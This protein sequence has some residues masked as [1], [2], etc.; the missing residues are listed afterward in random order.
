M[1]INY[2]IIYK[3]YVQRIFQH[4]LKCK[5][6]K[7]FILLVLISLIKAVKI[8]ANDIYPQQSKPDFVVPK[9]EC[10]IDVVTNLR[11]QAQLCYVH[12]K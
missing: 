4:F 5:K 1:T 3:L 6:K 9:I 2:L 11:Y 8:R 10:G 7:F 12:K